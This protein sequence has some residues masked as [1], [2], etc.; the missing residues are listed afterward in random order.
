[1]NVVRDVQITTHLLNDLAGCA[2][3]AERPEGVE[4]RAEVADEL[5]AGYVTLLSG[6]DYW[7][8][9]SLT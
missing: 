4:N 7:A 9:I 6:H 5:R 8:S 3:A 2:R 1:L